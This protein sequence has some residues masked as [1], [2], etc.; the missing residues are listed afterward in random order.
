MSAIDKFLIRFNRY[1]AYV[2]IAVVVSIL[3]FGYRLTGNFQFI[4]QGLAD[5]LHKVYLNIV[6]LFLFLTHTLLSLRIVLMRKNVK[7]KLLDVL[8]I[9]IG[10]GVFG[11]FS[12]LSL[13]LLLAWDLRM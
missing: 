3:L 6:F 10:V 8:F 9:M 1:L 5:L 2:L 7:K 4:P 13:R 12:F 11:V